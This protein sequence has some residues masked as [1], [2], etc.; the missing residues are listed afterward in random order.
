MSHTI[1]SGFTL[2]EILVSISIFSVL[3]ILIAL[4]FSNVFTGSKQ[5]L[6]AVDNIEQSRLVT[7]QFLNE[8]RNATTGVDGSYALGQA[9]DSQIIFYAKTKGTNTVN[10]VRYYLSAGKLYKG[11]VVPTGNPLAYNLAS[12]SV[13][14]AQNDVT[15]ATIFAYYDDTYSGTQNPLSQPIN[16]NSV[17]FIKINMTVKTQVKDNSNATFTVSEGVAIRGLKTNLGN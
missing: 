13:K 7:S 11:I 16:I 12:E 10:R 6:L 15:N 9:G 1:E 8:M 5:Q 4:M 17:K 2:V 3:I 14:I